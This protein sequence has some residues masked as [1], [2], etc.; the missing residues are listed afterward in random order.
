MKLVGAI[1]V[2]LGLAAACSATGN[3]GDSKGGTGGAGANG[4]SGGSGGSGNAPG[5]GGSG[6]TISTDGSSGTSGAGG[7]D[8][9]DAAC[10][11]FTQEAKQLY[12]PADIIWAVDTSGSM[13]E[14]AAA[15]QQNINS[16]SQQIVATGID[17]HV[18]MLAAYKF[19]VL[20]GICVPVPLGS[21]LCPPNGS[22]TKLP[23]FF[24]H[25]TAMIDSVDAARKL[26]LFYPDYK[27]HLRQNSLKYLV[28]VTDDDSRTGS[29]SGGTGDPGP[30]DNNPDKFIADFTALD[31]ML[32][33]GAGNPA[34]TL[35]AVYSFTQCPNAAAVGQVWK[36]IVDKTGGIHGDICNCPPGQPQQC[37]QTFQTI[38]NTL[39]TKIITGSQ[40][41]TCEWLIPPP[42]AGQTLDPNKVNVD[43]IDQL[44]GTK[45][46]IYHVNDASQCHPTQGGWY[47]DNNSAPTSIKV[48]PATCN[49]ITAV[50]NGKIEV[51]FG[52]ATKNL[53][54]T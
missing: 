31:P 17:V 41:L 37:A 49:A 4:G 27:Q 39:A 16:F 48:C 29:G 40:P 7:T 2:G 32:S 20:P 33:D 14:E 34:W 44:Q 45:Q 24:H 5:S 9:G 42:P 12:E 50:Q 6:G 18:V 21:G 54:P 8:P 30:Y 47:Y 51:V 52:C 43:F 26:V 19:F 46:T 3:S 22:D 1:V 38:F 36:Q 53:P 25:P 28:V 15:V 11:S 23:N 10:Q 35:S 13:I